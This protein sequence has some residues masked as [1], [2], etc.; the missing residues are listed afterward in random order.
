MQF[1]LLWI[2]RLLHLASRP[3]VYRRTEDISYAPWDARSL[4]LYTLP[5]GLSDQ[6]QSLPA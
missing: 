6:R 5:L 3:G 1:G 4:A 2:F